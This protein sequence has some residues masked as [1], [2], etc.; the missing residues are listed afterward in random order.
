[1]PP[2]RNRGRNNR[3][4]DRNRGRRSFG[5]PN[6]GRQQSNN[7]NSNR[8]FGFA[9]PIA[10]ATNLSIKDLPTVQAQG[11]NGKFICYATSDDRPIRGSNKSSR[12]GN[13]GKR[14]R[15]TFRSA[16]AF[17]RRPLVE[18]SSACPSYGRR[19]FRS[20]TST[21]LSSTTDPT[22]P[23]ATTASSTI[24]NDADNQRSA[25]ALRLESLSA[26]AF[27]YRLRETKSIERRRLT[28]VSSTTT[29]TTSDKSFRQ[30]N[31]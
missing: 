24:S 27:H 15:P 22:A 5:R 9:T 17:K 26:R 7:N 3:N 13:H 6:Y 16:I 1:M 2:T 19:R 18:Q 8:R 10:V 23:Q 31:F 4:S 30:R 25:I 20:I 12:K 14:R 11:P 21:S 28:T 29:T